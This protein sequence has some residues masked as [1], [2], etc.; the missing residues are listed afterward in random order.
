[1]SR[2]PGDID[3]IFHVFALMKTSIGPLK[4]ILPRPIYFE[5][6]FGQSLFKTS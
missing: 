1:M 4:D 3:S 2:Y 6:D 5:I